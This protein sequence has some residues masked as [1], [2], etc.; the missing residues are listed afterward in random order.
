MGGRG[1]GRTFLA[2]RS[3]IADGIANFRRQ[4][5][6]CALGLVLVPLYVKLTTKKTSVL[7]KLKRVDYIGGFFFIG[8]MTSFLVGISWA[9]IQFE[10]NSVQA[11]APMAI[12]VFGVVVSVFWECYGAPEP[13]LRPS[14]FH[15]PSALATYACAL[16]QGFI[17]GP[18]LPTPFSVCC[19]RPPPS[20][21]NFSHVCSFSV[22]STTSHSTSRPSNSS[23]RRRRGW[24]S[25]Q[26][27]ASFSPAA[28]SFPF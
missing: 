15:S 10:W 28:S 7:S 26:S 2:E 5:P 25:S 20:R 4:F 6:F 9:G 14:L 1:A 18:S 3:S 22:H 13:F 8:G 24:T 27:R 12:G 17:V 11:V 21:A 16:F 19:V 23:S